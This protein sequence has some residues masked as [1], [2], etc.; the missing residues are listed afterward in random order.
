MRPETLRAWWW[1]RSGLDGSLRG[2]SAAEVLERSGWMRSVGGAGPY[3]GLHA[4]SGLSRAAIDAALAAVEI[5]ELPSAR[6]CTYVLPASEYALGLRAGQGTSD[7]SDL[8]IAKKYLG[9]TDAEVEAL[10]EGVLAALAKENLDPKGLKDALG[11]RVRSLGPE[12]KK[13]GQTTT[14]PLALG[15][16]QAHGRIRRIPVNGRLDQQRYAYTRWDPSPIQGAAEP[17]GVRT[18][19]AR[20]FFRWSGPATLA[21]FTAFGGWG[22]R[23]SKAAVEPLGLVPVGDDR[24]LLPEDKAAFDSFVA[25]KEPQVNFL[26]NLDNLLLARR[27]AGS[28]LDA[29]DS[30]RKVWTE[31]GLQAGGALM[32]LSNQAIVDRGRIIGLWDWDGLKNELVW[33]TFG[34]AGEA[35]RAEAS[36]MSAW[37]AE[38][39]GDVRSFSLDSPESRVPRIDAIRTAHNSS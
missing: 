29:A 30:G 35:V 33:S 9:V 6:G 2:K 19:L 25:P 28:L 26:S 38:N 24:L 20:R 34:P 5:H 36:R 7:A 8:A 31:K 23:D 16:L 21:Q 17:A 10:K 22:V 13:R 11:D 4:R 32:D 12:G 39:L 3:L 1:S 37:I 27:D 18:E 14:L 15:W